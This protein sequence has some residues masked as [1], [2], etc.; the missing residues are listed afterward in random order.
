[1]VHWHRT[2]FGTTSVVCHL[3]SKEAKQN[4]GCSSNT[5]FF[6]RGRHLCDKVEV[7]PYSQMAPEYTK[8]NGDKEHDTTEW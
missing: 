3:L 4:K 7:K 8:C 1:M 6:W 5:F 2:S